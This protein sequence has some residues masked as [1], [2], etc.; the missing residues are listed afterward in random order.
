[1]LVLGRFE[2][3]A[4]QIGNDIRVVIVRVNKGYVRVGIQAPAD[5]AIVRE[6]IREDTD[7]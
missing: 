1:M 2:G 6:E 4:I 7:G 5:V 3:E